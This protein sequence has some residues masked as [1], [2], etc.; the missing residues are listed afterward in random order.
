M[1]SFKP[2]VETILKLEREVTSLVMVI[3]A[4]LDA[5]PATTAQWSIIGR[6]LQGAAT[7]AKRIAKLL[8]NG[9]DA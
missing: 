3:E 8:A 2:T 7:R 6:Q 9:M 1:K 4:R 5:S